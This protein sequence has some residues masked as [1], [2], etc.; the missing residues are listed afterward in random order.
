MTKHSSG[1]VGTRRSSVLE[2]TENK[3]DLEGNK[4]IIDETTLHKKSSLCFN[5]VAAALE[6]CTW[7]GRTQI[8]LGRTIDFYID[9]AHTDESIGCCVAWFK[10]IIKNTKWV[11]TFSRKKKMLG[12]ELCQND[13]NKLFFYRKERSRYLIF[14]ATGDRDSAKLLSPL[15]EL[16]F[17]KA[18]FVPNVAGVVYSVDQENFNMP[19]ANQLEKARKH[20]DIWGENSV[21]A[22]NVYEALTMIRK[23][24]EASP[25]SVERC[26][27]QVLTTGSLHLVGALL[28]IIDSEL[29]MSTNFW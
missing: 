21:L 13:D 22:G 9:G 2:S 29:T 20:A 10:N 24:S 5:K 27:P 12:K 3:P 18:F 7:P 16:G 17:K 4:Y 28:S 23:E 11:Y 6:H 26:K 1:R 8:L 19:V 14:N 25:A 15:K